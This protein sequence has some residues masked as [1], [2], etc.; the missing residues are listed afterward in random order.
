MLSQTVPG[1]KFGGL[2]WPVLMIALEAWVQVKENMVM[3]A[4]GFS[5][6]KAAHRWPRRHNRST[7][8]ARKPYKEKCTKNCAS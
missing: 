3:S 7:I 1:A 6:F 2:Y 5:S 4:F 8:G